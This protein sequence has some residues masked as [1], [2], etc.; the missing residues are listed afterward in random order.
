MDT[1]KYVTCSVY[2]VPVDSVFPLDD[3]PLGVGLARLDEV[4]AAAGVQLQAVGP[5]AVARRAH[6]RTTTTLLFYT[7]G[8]TRPSERA[9]P[10]RGMRL[11]AMRHR[12]TSR[13]FMRATAS[14]VRIM[15][16]M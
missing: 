16:E 13:P 12:M 6:L 5:L 1:E 14:C 4:G 3:L 15:S 7:Y 10:E 9:R 2:M 8:V 11:R